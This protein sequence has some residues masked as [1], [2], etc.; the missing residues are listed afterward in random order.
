MTSTSMLNRVMSRARN[1]L[2]HLSKIV[3]RLKT[4]I[5]DAIFLRMLRDV[6]TGMMNMGKDRSVDS[7]VSLHLK[8]MS[9]TRQKQEYEAAVFSCVQRLK[10]LTFSAHMPTEGSEHLNKV[11]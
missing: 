11:L 9:P 3:S 7:V 6:T 1:V 2:T 5:S 4:N 8:S 10:P